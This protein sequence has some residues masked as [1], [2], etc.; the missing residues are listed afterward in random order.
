MF[1]L[2]E[3]V[4]LGAP[5]PWFFVAKAKALLTSAVDLVHEDIVLST[6][7]KHKFIEVFLVREY[8][9]CKECVK[10]KGLKLSMSERNRLNARKVGSITKAAELGFVEDD[11]RHYRSDIGEKIYIVKGVDD[12]RYAWYI[13]YI[14]PV[15]C[16][17]FLKGLNDDIIHLDNHGIILISAYGDNPPDATSVEVKRL[18]E[19][20]SDAIDSYPALL[21]KFMLDYYNTYTSP[22]NVSNAG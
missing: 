4:Y 8:W 16:G 18:Y 22:R 14:D 19:C 6:I 9:Y 15:K 1:N 3:N 17:E 12:S 2:I 13:V 10:A 21:C 5:D 11:F 7:L 20:D